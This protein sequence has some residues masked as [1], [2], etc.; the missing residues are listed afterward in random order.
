V[1]DFIIEE[2]SKRITAKDKKYMTIAIATTI[3]RFGPS[4]SLKKKNSVLENKRDVIP[5]ISN[6][7][8]FNLK[9]ILV[10]IH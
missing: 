10:I 3:R 8:F 5:R 7:I 1:G 6:E 4:G 9:R 2:L